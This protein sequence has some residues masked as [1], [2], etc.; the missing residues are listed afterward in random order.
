M[1]RYRHCYVLKNK[2]Y[3]HGRKGDADEIAFSSPL[4]SL[5]FHSS[6]I[7]GRGRRSEVLKNGFDS[8]IAAAVSSFRIHEQQKKPEEESRVC[9]TL[10][11]FLLSHPDHLSSPRILV[12]AILTEESVIIP[13]SEI[14]RD[15]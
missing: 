12:A 5:F 2:E 4:L 6:G 14:C 13:L 3:S 1:N 9:R 7:Q 8:A 11:L 15:G 10:S